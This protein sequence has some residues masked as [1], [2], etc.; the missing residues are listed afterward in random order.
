MGRGPGGAG[1]CRRDR[2]LSHAAGAEVARAGPPGELGLL[3]AAG[4][5]QGMASA[6]SGVSEEV[7]TGPGGGTSGLR[8]RT[9]GAGLHWKAGA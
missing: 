2:T 5:G 3:G 1:P 7:A 9:G 4:P 6:G 8:V